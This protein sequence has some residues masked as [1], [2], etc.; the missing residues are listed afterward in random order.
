MAKTDKKTK[1]ITQETVTKEFF[2][3]HEG[4]VFQVSDATK[5]IKKIYKKKKGVEAEDIPRKIRQ[6]AQRGWLQKPMENSTVKSGYYFYDS[7]LENNKEKSEFTDKQK[8]EIYKLHDG[9]CAIC[10]RS[11]KDGVRMI[12][13]H[14]TPVNKGGK[15]T[16]ENG[17]LLCEICSNNKKDY[18]VYTF[19]TKLW[20]NYRKMAV[21]QNDAKL[22]ELCD[23][24][25][26]IFEKHGLGTYKEEKEKERAE[27]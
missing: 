17:Q 16:I 18:G 21:E 4:E 27:S 22:I 15:A 19:G 2:K 5:E 13:D 1:K 25:L 14:I 10:G 24:I 3:K 8:K 11:K 26:K 23:D 6:L 9:K 12:A 7:T 20:E